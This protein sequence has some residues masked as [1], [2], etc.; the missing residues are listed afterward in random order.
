MAKA[1]LVFSGLLLVFWSGSMVLIV[2]L[3]NPTKGWIKVD[4]APMV[5]T[6]EGFGPA[7]P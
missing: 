5:W 6:I 4:P 7:R 3:N 1:T 2:D